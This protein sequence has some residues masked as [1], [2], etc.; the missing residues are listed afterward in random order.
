[1]S[2]ITHVSVPT[3]RRVRLREN[4]DSRAVAKVIGVRDIKVRYK[5]SF[6]GP[7]W[8]LIQPLAMLLGFIVVFD[9]VANVD[10]GDVPYAIFALVG[11]TVWTYLQIALTQGAMALVANRDLIRRFNCP[12][13]AFSNASMISALASP[14]VMLVV[15]VVAVVASS[16]VRLSMLLLPLLIVWLLGLTWGLVL[17]CS[18]FT[19]RFRDVVGIL[20]FLFQAALFL[21]PVAYP[22]S[23][24]PESIR[25]LLDLNPATGLLEA[26]RWAMI[27]T[28]VSMTALAVSL[29]ASVLTMLAGWQI[30]TRMEVRFADFI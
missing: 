30:F 8:L 22:A 2:G 24:A 21:T 10:T 25:G 6:L 5:Q 3:A 12:R 26:W 15:T 14:A 13:V 1:M 23:A 17:M 11:L 19:A 20:P 7:L 29:V 28:D 16:G 27:G 18:S 9:G 4:W